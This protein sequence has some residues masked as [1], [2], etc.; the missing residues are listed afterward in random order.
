MS[1]N[2]LIITQ[3]I[4]TN[5]PVLG[6]FHR[7]AKEF[8]KHCEKLTVICL[9]KGEYHLP[10]NVKVFSL[11]KEK[12]AD[13]RESQHQ[14]KFGTGQARR[15]LTRIKY[16]LN[17]YKYIW[18]ERKNYDSVFVHMNQEYILLGGLIWKLLGKKTMFWRN[19]PVGN[20]LTDIA[21]FFSDKIFCTSKYSYTAKFKK[22]QI[23]PVGIDTELFKRKL[24]TKKMS[25]SILFLSRISPIK[26]PDL[27]IESL[28]LLNKEEI[29]FNAL[30]VG[31]P[32]LKD[33]KYYQEIK[34]NVEKYNLSQKIVFRS[35]VANKETIEFYNKYEIFVNL[36]PSGM[37]DKTIFEAMAC[38]ALVLTSNKNLI[39]EI[40]DAFIFAENNPQ[41]LAIK[42]EKL[43]LLDDKERGD[44]SL[45]LRDYVV[46]NHNLKTLVQKIFSNL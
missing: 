34:D 1:K 45:F 8:A 35:G 22:I 37:F 10:E 17:F 4:D 46:E 3:T 41:D 6:F 15:R 14:N 31:N 26:K 23:M 42:L 9:E 18:Q 29:N 2:I 12:T 33:K 21:V 27:L 43:L 13:L 39:G 24:E 38:E 5:N 25:N 32:L 16:I 19:H 30:I 28:N 44:M 20:F 40:D 36:S 7:W 11:G